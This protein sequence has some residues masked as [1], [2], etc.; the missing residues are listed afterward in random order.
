MNDPVKIIHRANS[1]GHADYGWLNTYHT[2]SFANY[3]DPERVQ[4]GALRVLND[5]R[6][7]PSKGFDFHPHK[8]ME[9]ISI[10]LKGGLLHK[11]NKNNE[12]RIHNGDVQIMSAG[13][14]II[15]SEYNISDQEEVQFL[16]IWILPNEKNINPGY[17]Q[18]TF[19]AEKEPNKMQLLVNPNTDDK[20]T[21]NIHQNAFIS[22]GRFDANSTYVYNK[23]DDSNGVYVFVIDGEVALEGETL[24]QRDGIGLTGLQNIQFNF[25]KQT[26]ILLLEV[27]V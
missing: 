22:R 10:P 21:L 13:T 8:N 4:F 3:Y 15:H 11:D 7:A 27:P 12:I 2:F 23:F 5:D 25:N 16:Q 17:D 1:R 6:V 14:G 18:M 26:D 19:R 9:I 24:N 20:S